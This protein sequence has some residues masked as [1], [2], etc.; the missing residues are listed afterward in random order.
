MTSR[1][2]SSPTP[3]GAHGAGLAG[4]ALLCAL[5]AAPSLAA[6]QTVIDLTYD[7]IMDMVRP[8]NHPGI[9]VHHNLQVV[10]SEGN[11]VSEKRDRATG[12]YADNNAMAQ[13]LRSSG[14]EGAYAAWHVLSA[15]QLVRIERDPQSTRTMTVTLTSPT[16]C[17]LEVRD[18]L[19]PGFNEY[20]FLRISTHQLGYFST[21]QVTST[22][23]AIR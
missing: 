10:L 9:S 21:Y 20:A 11:K 22:S 12:R 7:S 23:C 2:E 15:S 13:L 8:E 14:N 6:S 4:A 19:K 1:Q 16:A 5:G 3:S 17:R 18:Q